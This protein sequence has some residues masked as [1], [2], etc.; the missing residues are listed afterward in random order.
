[1]VYIYVYKITNSIQFN[2][3]NKAPLEMAT[4]LIYSSI[5]LASVATLTLLYSYF[6]QPNP[7]PNPYG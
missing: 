4:L 6:Y 3:Y 5:I 1:M 2:K 7:T